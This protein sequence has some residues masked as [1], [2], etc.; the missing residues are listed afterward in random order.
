MFHKRA[1]GLLTVLISVQRLRTDAKRRGVVA[2]GAAARRHV[3]RTFQ[4]DRMVAAYVETFG[5]DKRRTSFV[6]DVDGPPTRRLAIVN[7]T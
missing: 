3:E 7:K 1:R 2:F 4:M 6:R 5:G